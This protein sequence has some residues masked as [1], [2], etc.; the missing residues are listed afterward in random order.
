MVTHLSGLNLKLDVVQGSTA[1]ADYTVS[2]ITPEDTLVQVTAVTI[3][4]DATYGFDVSA[5]SRLAGSFSIS[6]DNTITDGGTT[7]LSNRILFVL[8]L[9]MDEPD[10]SQE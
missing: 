10:D 6:D 8:W 1:G 9:D 2:G 5:S 7:N 3:A 4:A